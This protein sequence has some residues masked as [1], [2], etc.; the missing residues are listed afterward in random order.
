MYSYEERIRAVKLYIKLG[1]RLKATILQLGYPTK[2]SLISWYRE[3]VEE[4]DLCAGYSRST[5]KFSAE[6]KQQAVQHFLGHDRCI[7]STIKALG[8]P[9]RKTLK[10]WIDELHPDV[11]KRVVGRSANIEHSPQLKQAAVIELCT[12]QTNAQEIAQRLAVSRPTLYNWKDQLLGRGSPA[13][14]SSKKK[15]G[16]TPDKSQLS[17]LQQQV[18]SLERDVRRLRL[19][20]DILKKANEL[21]KKDLGV[22]PQFLSNREKTILV[23]ALKHIYTLAELLGELRLA[24]SSYFYHFARLRMPD[25]YADARQLLAEVFH[26]NHSCYGYRRMRAALRR[27]QL[28]LSE[29]VVQRLMKQERL[30]VAVHRKRR[31]GSYMGEISPAPENIINRDFR[32]SAPNEKWLTDITEFQ[33]PA[34]KVYLSPM[35]DCF[36]GLVVSWTIGTRPDSEL[37]N[38]MLDAAIDTVTTG[39]TRPVVHSDR[40]GHYRWPGWLKRMNDAS[41]IRS[42][43]RK[44]C[45]PDNA[46]CEGFFGRLK[47]EMFYPKNWQDIS[48][49]QFM[50]SVDAYIRWYNEKR[51]KVSLGSLSPMEYRASLG[52]TT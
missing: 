3:Y 30:I 37:V 18:E 4:R 50:G 35:I 52:I 20:H 1:K 5:Q 47:T 17:E 49:D 25:K 14:M 21:L 48:V 11:R 36:D 40:G 29:K 24:R 33:I 39:E 28:H 42:M 45:S 41:L 31:Y 34:G 9:C 26:S 16:S 23:D 10:D 13:L 15:S 22:T 38:A 43:S 8:Y 19:E 12:R 51:I 6:Q 2:N 7:A 27:H 46:A 32:A 44:G